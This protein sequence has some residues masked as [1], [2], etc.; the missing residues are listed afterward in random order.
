MRLVNELQ[1][2]SP[3]SKELWSEQKLKSLRI[4]V[5]WNIVKYYSS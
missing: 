2:Y 5:I 3:V 1:V 4:L